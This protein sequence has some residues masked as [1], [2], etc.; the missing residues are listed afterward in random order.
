MYIL[1]YSFIIS[2]FR[3]I[4]NLFVAK[5]VDITLND[6]FDLYLLFPAIGLITLLPFIS[7]SDL[8]NFWFKIKN[9]HKII[10]FYIGGMIL[11]LFSRYYYFKAIIIK[12]RETT[13]IPTVMYSSLPIIISGI[14]YNLLGLESYSFKTY[15]FISLILIGN[16]GV[17]LFWNYL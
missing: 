5:G 17:Y 7:S 9:N 1:L 13:Y 15:F 6:A 10:F 4:R 12:K 3:S 14:I 2:L 16:I 11:T 8:I